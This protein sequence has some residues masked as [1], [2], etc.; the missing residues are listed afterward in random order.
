MHCPP[1]NSDIK[2]CKD[3]KNDNI[4]LPFM[5]DETNECDVILLVNMR[6]AKI[7]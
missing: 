5:I 4:D 6:I 1:E 7:L 3:Y 2:L